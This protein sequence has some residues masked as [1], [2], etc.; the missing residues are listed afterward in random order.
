MS[1]WGNNDNAAN[2]PLWAA[3][4]VF[5]APTSANTTALFDN[6]TQDAF[7]ANATI[8][9]FGVDAQEAGAESAAAHTGWVLR[10]VGVGGRAGKGHC[11]TTIGT[12]SPRCRSACSKCAACCVI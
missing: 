10:T 3:A 7:V 8:G 6:V 11:R 4:S 5:L 2:V 12:R 9:V 1:S